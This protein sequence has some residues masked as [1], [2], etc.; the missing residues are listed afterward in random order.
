M[1]FKTHIVYT[2]LIILSE[3]K[4]MEGTSV[5]FYNIHHLLGDGAFGEVW[6]GRHAHD[7]ALSV[8]IKVFHPSLANDDEFVASIKSESRI[9]NTLQHRN[10]VGFRE[11]V[12][13]DGFVALV[14]EHLNGDN[15]A[16]RLQKESLPA[17]ELYRVG[18]Q[19]LEALSSV[20][21]RKIFHRYIKPSNI[22]FCDNGTI[23]ILDFGIATAVKG[24][25]AIQSGTIQETVQYS[26]PELFKSE[27]ANSSTDVYALGLSLWELYTGEVACTGS[28]TQQQMSWHRSQGLQS[29][30]NSTLPLQMRDV[31][32][33]FC[34][35]E[36]DN[37]PASVRDA[38]EMWSKIDLDDDIDSYRQQPIL[39]RAQGSKASASTFGASTPIEKSVG[40]SPNSVQSVNMSKDNMT[41]KSQPV[42]LEKEPKASQ[43]NAPPK[44]E[45]PPNDPPSNSG[46]ST[47][48]YVLIAGIVLVLGGVTLIG[49]AGL[50]YYYR[51]TDGANEQD[52]YYSAYPEPPTA[53]RA[54]INL[55]I[56]VEGQ[57]LD[58]SGGG[59]SS[60]DSNVKEILVQAYD[61]NGSSSIN[62]TSEL[63]AI[64]CSV[65]EAIEI[66][67]KNGGEYSS[68]FIN[69]Y[70]F[71]S[72]GGWMGNLLGFDLDIR[73]GAYSRASAC[74]GLEEGQVIPTEP[75]ERPPTVVQPPQSGV[76]AQILSLSGGGSSSWD[77]NVKEILVQAYDDNGSASINTTSEVN[78]IP[79]SVFEAIEVSLKNGGEYSSGFINV[80][81]FES[82]GGW[83]GNLL[84]F[85]LNIRSQAYRNA[86][87][88]FGNDVGT[89]PV[90][91]QTSSVPAQILSLSGGGSS[92]WDDKVKAIIVSNY[93]T[94][95]GGTINS[96][97]EV[98][99]IPCSVFQAIDTSLLNGGEY[100]SSFVA[101]YGFVPDYIWIG[102]AFG[103]DESVRS[104]AYSRASSCLGGEPSAPTPVPSFSSG[105]V[106]SQILSLSGGG[107]S[108]WDDKV[109]GIL[110]LEYDS[111]DSNDIDS[112]SEVSA[113]PC[114][115]FQAIDT[116]LLNGGE[117]SSSFIA[118]YGFEP[119]F[120]WIGYAFGFDESVRSI[121]YIRAVAC[122]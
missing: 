71:E 2:L 60:W 86:E 6:L 19:L 114:S 36:P 116:S 34:A 50:F 75:T 74:L 89:A 59:S 91:S 109:K 13:K 16:E 29:R 103:F 24:A 61:D 3:E 35:I 63:N 88:C 57:I 9:L 118:V 121:A 10:I 65:F 26:A 93:D 111:N 95:G 104:T 42:G 48:S 52:D 112:S 67:L 55:L 101:V 108:V 90:P 1:V 99:A 83:M 69:V 4:G 100:S 32:L 21:D 82:D 20:H 33:S 8:A 22:F 107:S 54:E 40:Q 12:I 115:V 73:S 79:C 80:Y 49:G 25:K 64:P 119:D 11:L 23:K 117:Y 45:A 56:S 66:S 87:T 98:N 84:G 76:E 37:R 58:L 41:N 28:S 51:I 47:M 17:E 120:I 38:L 92:A 106:A 78:A 105:G 102:Y 77:S 5:S 68:G 7:P 46:G 31:L 110:L 18:Y 96:A 70:N 72:D 94:S 81:N 122:L 14:M 44:P 39:G 62:T 15:G 53:E 97:N 30:D 43:R 27:K 85:H 113:I